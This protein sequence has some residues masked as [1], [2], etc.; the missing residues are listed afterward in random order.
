MGRRDEV[1]RAARNLQRTLY[2]QRNE[3][4]RFAP[5][6]LDL[7]DPKL[8]A[9]KVL[10]A[11]FLTRQ[12]LFYDHALYGAKINSQIAGYVDRDRG[13]IVVSERLPLEVFR[14]TG[15]HE[16]G[17]WLLHPGQNLF[18]EFP[19]S[20]EERFKGTRKTEE[21]EADLFAA[22]FLMPE[23]LIRSEF[24]QRFSVP[25]LIGNEVDERL[26]SLLSMGAGGYQRPSVLRKRTARYRA[27]LAATCLPINGKEPYVS[28]AQLFRVSPI[29]M[30]IQLEDRGLVD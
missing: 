26:A 22:E 14:F 15:A 19:L 16:L 28:L 21:R 17:H 8:A 9:E 11:K 29:A 7:L 25:A 10:G 23:R 12:D 2:R 20:D 6:T 18:R 4:W 13:E 3:Y 27:L 1:I 30:A 5:S 24:E